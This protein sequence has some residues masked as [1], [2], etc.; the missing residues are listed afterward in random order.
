MQLSCYCAHQFDSIFNLRF[1]LENVDALCLRSEKRLMGVDAQLFRLFNSMKLLLTVFRNFIISHACISQ[2]RVKPRPDPDR[3]DQETKWMTSK[4]ILFEAMKPS[5]RWIEAGSGKLG[6]IYLEII[7][8]DNLPNMDAGPKDKTDAFCCVIY[9]DAIVNT[10]V[11][12]DELSPRWMPWT[13]RAFVF[14]V[15]HP[16]SQVL[17][18]VLDYDSERGLNSHDAI[19]RISVDIT[20]FRADTEYLLKYNLFKSVLDDD[21]SSLGTLTLRLRIEYDSF[22][23]FVKGSF[24][25]PPFNYINLPKKSDFKTAFFVCHGDENLQKFDLQVMKSYKNELEGYLS[26]IYFVTKAVVTVVLWRGHREFR[27]LGM[28]FKPPVHSMVAFVMGI[29]LIENFDYLP[30][31]FFFSIAWLLLATN[32][33]RQ[34]NPSP[35][36]VSMTYLQMWYSVLRDRA[37]PIEIASYENEGAIRKFEAETNE[38]KEA[39]VARA[40]EA[41]ERAGQLAS[42]LQEEAQDKENVDEDISTKVGGGTIN[43]LSKALL[44]MQNILGLVCRWLRIISSVISWDESIYAFL[45]VNACLAVGILLL[46]VPWGLIIRWTLRI[47]IWVALGPWMK[48]VDIYFVQ[49]LSEDGDNKAKK[50]REAAA[51]KLKTVGA[52]RRAIM[53]KKEEIMKLRAMKAYMFGK[54]VT[55]VPQFKEYRFPDVPRAESSAQPCLRNKSVSVKKRSCGQRLEGAMIPTWGDAVDEEG[56]EE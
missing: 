39:E 35:W 30:S 50:L 4:Q 8:C 37:P 16:S 43:P 38:R 55:R 17:I 27:F 3:P 19:G 41:Q 1:T 56:K 36:H 53:I 42:F 49:K 32:E 2:H 47:M 11:I 23:E 48:L 5:T 26:L 13:Q 18:G 28:K 7:K 21:R 24:T 6:K 44:P 10:D 34:S 33:L 29:F 31:F 54:F 52:A 40:K 20:N 51:N 25:I 22:R 46:L 45:I 9:E 12:N 14:R 15:Q